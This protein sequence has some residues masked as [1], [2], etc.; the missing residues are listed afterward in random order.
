MASGTTRRTSR[1]TNRTTR[2]GG[3]GRGGGSVIGILAAIGVVVLLLGA[4]IVWTNYK[5]KK[6]LEAANRTTDVVVA[7]VD[8]EPG[9]QITAQDITIKPWK[10]DAVDP[11]AFTNAADPGLIG[12]T[13]T[14][15]IFGGQ[16]VLRNFIGVPDEKLLPEEGEREVTLILK[17]ADSQQSFLRRG[18]IVSIFRVFNTASG[19]RITQ[20]LSKHARILE[21]K[22]SDNI[23][24]NAQNSG[25]SQAAVTLALSPADAQQVSAYQDQAKLLDG[26]NQE[27]PA[28]QVSL[29][30]KWMGIEMEEQE[31]TAEVGATKIV[32]DTEKK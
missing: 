7:A 31:L 8:L 15:K 9:H 29:F 13:I 20:S 5:A 30:Q 26:P 22:K 14:V 18:Q 16:P 19:N 12:G 25:E 2:S 27:P 24:A 23:V 4:F 11:Q 21:V 1:V 28:S 17:G 3:G 6:D 32:K 10:A